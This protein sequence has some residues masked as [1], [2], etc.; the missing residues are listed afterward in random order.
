MTSGIRISLLSASALLVCACAGNQYGG[1]ADASSFVEVA[2][3]DEVSIASCYLK[4]KIGVISTTGSSSSASSSSQGTTTAHETDFYS[5][6]DFK[7]N[8][9]SGSIIGHTEKGLY[10]LIN[11][12][13]STGFQFGSDEPLAPYRAKAQ[14]YLAQD[15]ATLSAVYATVRSYAGKTAAELGFSSLSVLATQAGDT[16]GYTAVTVQSDGTSKTELRYYITLDKVT[17]S[18]YVFTD[19]AI[20]RAVTDLATGSTNYRNEEYGLVHVSSFEGTDFVF[21]AA[22]YTIALG[23]ADISSIPSG[24]L[25]G[26]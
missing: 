20:R 1:V 21:N 12:L 8:G 24:V 15:Y 22:S 16:V 4:T 6:G 13:T 5:H 18:H 2:S 14:A 23:T 11:A 26:K 7:Y 17:E 9:D 3:L 19:V 10:F 25:V